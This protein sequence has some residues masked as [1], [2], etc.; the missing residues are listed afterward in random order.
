[1]RYIHTSLI[2]MILSLCGFSSVAT[3]AE[4]NIKLYTNYDPQ[5]PGFMPIVLGA[6]VDISLIIDGELVVG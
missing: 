2:M 5:I 4:Q 6:E 1:M 3:S